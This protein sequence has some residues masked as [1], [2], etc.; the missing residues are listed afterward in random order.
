MF[1]VARCWCDY[2]CDVSVEELVTYVTVMAAVGLA[3]LLTV[4]VLVLV[5]LLVVEVELVAMGTVFQGPVVVVTRVV[6]LAVLG[7]I[8]G[9]LAVFL[10]TFLAP[11]T[12]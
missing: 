8:V 1:W 11:R 9:L 12:C 10:V 6:G 7:L 2:R 4:D 5:T 3:L